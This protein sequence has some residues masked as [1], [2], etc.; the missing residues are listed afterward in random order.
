MKTVTGPALLDI[1]APRF[2][3]DINLPTGSVEVV[4]APHGWLQEAHAFKGIEEY[5]RHLKGQPDSAAPIEKLTTQVAEGVKETLKG[6]PREDIDRAVGQAYKDVLF[7]FFLHQQVNGKVVSEE[8]HYWSQAMLLANMLG[9]LLREQAL[10]D[11]MRS[12][13]IRVE[14]QMPYPLDSE[15]AAAVE[16][17]KRHHVLTWEVLEEG[18]DLGKWVTAGFLAEGNTALPDGAY[19][20]LK[21]ATHL[22]SK[23]PTEAE[24]KELFQDPENFQKFLDGEDYSY[25]LADVLDEEYNE[26]YEAIVC[27]V[28]GV[29]QEGCVVDLPTVPHQFLREAP[30]V[31]GDWI[32]LYIVE[33]AEW[34]ARI[35]EKGFLLEEPDDNHPLAWHR[36]NDPADGTEVDASVTVRLWQQTR[37][38]LAKLPGGTTEIDGRVYVSFEDYLKWRGRR[39]KGDLKSSV[40]TGPVVAQ[41]NHWVEGQGDEGVAALAEV[42]VGKLDCYL[43]GYQYR[44]CRDA[45]ELAEEVSIRESLLDSLGTQKLGEDRFRQRVGHWKELALRFLPEI[46]TVRGAISEINRRYFEGQEVLFLA[47]AEGFDQLLDLV[48]KAVDIFNESLAGDIERLEK[49]LVETGNRQDASPL[50]IDLSGLVG[51]VHGAAREQ[52][53]YLVDMA[54]ADA[55]DLLGETRQALELVDRHV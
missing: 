53:A 18:D 52:V 55:L 5:V 44:V 13:Q 54:K 15:T 14:L 43:S 34:G 36:I 20:L 35:N 49:L 9:S 21:G 2:C 27:A 10:I 39:N 23:V 4:T 42:K 45:T 22:Y 3:P 7:L 12:N 47:E 11:R 28:K 24:V 33:L 26:H 41:W 19:G 8:R 29:A 25:G 1:S 46:Y 6:K 51:N 50:T 17:A 38:H 16:A 32:D 40:R 30:L 37:K 48:E 31:E